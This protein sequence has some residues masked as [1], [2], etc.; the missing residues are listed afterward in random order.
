MVRTPELSQAVVRRS[1]ERSMAQREQSYVQE[2]QRIVDATYRL[3]AR[4]GSFD[5]RLRDILRESGLSTQA[6]YKHFRSK[7]E[8]MLVLLDD[9]R[10]RLVGYLAHRMEK[11]GTPEGRVRAWIEG[12]LAQAADPDVAARTRPFLAHQDRLAEQFPEEQQEAVDLLLGLLADAVADLPGGRSAAAA[13][14]DARAVYEVSFGTLHA[15]VSRGT[16]PSAAETDHL[17][18]FCLKGIGAP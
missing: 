12:V 2:V 16:R 9:G 7:D 5:P 3:V 11:E 15:H 17:V 13:R 14:R 1:L 18:Q 10:R 8:L 6:F 4:T